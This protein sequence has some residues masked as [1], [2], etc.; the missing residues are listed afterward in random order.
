MDKGLAAYKEEGIDAH[1]YVCDV[2]DENAVNELVAKIG[3]GS[4]RD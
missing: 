3:E 2:T 1:G 4:G